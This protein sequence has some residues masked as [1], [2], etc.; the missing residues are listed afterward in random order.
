[1]NGYEFGPELT[2]SG[3]HF[4]LWAPAAKTVEL[5]ADRPLPMQTADGAW[6]SL[7]FPAAGPG[8]RYKFRIDGSLEV[9]DPASAFQPDDVSGQSEVIDHR[10]YQ[11][12]IRD[13]RGRPWHE[14][15][16]L[17]LHVGAFTP[18]GTFRSAI[19]KLD[20]VV[21][22]GFTAIELMPIA[23]FAGRRNWGYDGVLLYAPD[24]A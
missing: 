13:W 2:P 8:A 10:S 24:S 21:R 23:D 17:E 3:V 14:A 18:S 15:A 19:D 6:Y 16:I 11:W 1:V 20:H 12:V 7:R 22:A 4:R 9:P 5:L